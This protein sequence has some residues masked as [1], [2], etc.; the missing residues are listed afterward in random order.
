M[1]QLALIGIIL[2]GLIMIPFGLPGT[3]VIFCGALGYKL[4]VPAGGIGWFTV[5]LIGALMIFAEALEWALTAKYTRKYGGS[6]RAS[7][8]AIIGGMVG[9]FLG[10]PVPVIGSVIGAF[11]GAF[12]GAF[13]FE[14]SRAA[15]HGTAVRVAWG[16]LVGRVIA[17]TMKVGIGLAMGAWLVFASLT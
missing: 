1:A 13:V 6:R 12:V 10:V 17:A 4:L 2:L 7:W 9:A 8:G 3:L 15:Q 11:A 14:Y 16:A 5:G